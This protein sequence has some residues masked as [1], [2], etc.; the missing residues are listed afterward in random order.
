MLRG[1]AMAF[2]I[3]RLYTLYFWKIAEHIDDIVATFIA[4]AATLALV[5]VLES[6]RRSKSSWRAG[7]KIPPCTA[8][9]CEI[10]TSYW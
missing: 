1:Y 6:K 2:I 4:G 10:E 3:I 5:L 7:L 8:A 9:L